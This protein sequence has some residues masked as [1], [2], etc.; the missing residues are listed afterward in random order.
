VGPESDDQSPSHPNVDELAVDAATRVA[1]IQG[2][3]DAVEEVAGLQI[4]IDCQTQTSMRRGWPS[5]VS[6]L[7][8]RS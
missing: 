1:L 6:R 3:V 2:L 7:A 8:R 4:A 5:R